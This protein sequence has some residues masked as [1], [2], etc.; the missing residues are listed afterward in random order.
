VLKAIMAGLVRDG[1]QIEVEAGTINP[2]DLAGWKV[3]AAQEMAAIQAQQEKD[4][5]SER[6]REAVVAATN[7]EKQLLDDQRRR[8]DEA[9]RREKLEAMRRQ[10]QS[11]ATAIMDTFAKRLQRHMDSVVAEV[12]DTQQ[13]AKLG[14][15]LSRQ[16]QAAQ[17]AGYANDRMDLPPWSNQII[18]TIKEGWE[19]GA[20][21]TGI[22]DYGQAQWKHRT[23]E[24]ISVRVTYPRINKVIGEK[25]TACYVFSWIDDEEFSFMR[26]PMVNPCDEYAS[27]FSSWTQAT[28]FISQWNLLRPS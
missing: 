12:R 10:V 3:L 21:Q 6:R 19:L 7:Q 27:A 4:T 17:Q 11:K 5:A 13:R 2:E 23:I 9:A 8:N 26:Q 16:E 25:D 15:V 28:G 14:T 1:T 18:T 22:A 24:A 20:I